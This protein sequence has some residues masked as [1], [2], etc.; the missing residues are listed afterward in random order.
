LLTEFLSQSAALLHIDLEGYM[1][2][3]P[4]VPF[5]DEGLEPA[6]GLAVLII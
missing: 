1:P 2:V 5:P 3:V 4:T 6:W